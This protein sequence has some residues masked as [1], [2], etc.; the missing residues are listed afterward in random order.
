MIAD[1]RA[2]ALRRRILPDGLDRLGDDDDLWEKGLSSFACLDWMLAIE[3][4][5]E[6]EFPQAAITRDGFRSIAAVTRAV[7]RLIA[8]SA[9]DWRAAA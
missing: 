4:A 3:E 9:R 2:L 1:V 6:I 5:F 7:D 8:A